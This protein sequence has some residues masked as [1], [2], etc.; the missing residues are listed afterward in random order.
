MSKEKIWMNG[1]YLDSSEGVINISTSAL[2]YG[3]SIFEGILCIMAGSGKTS[4]V[5]RLQDHIDRMFES[6]GVLNYKIPYSRE[7]LESAVIGLV[8]INKYSSC[9]IRP[10]VFEDSGYLDFGNKKNILNIVILCKSF[11]HI[12][13]RWKMRS[14]AKIMISKTVRNLWPDVLIKA[15]ISGKYLASVIARREAEN[16]GFDD[17]LLLDSPGNVSEATSSNIFIIKSGVIKTPRRE[18]T[19]NGITQNSVMRIAK[20]FGYSVAEED[21]KVEDLLDADEAFLTNTAAGIVPISSIDSKKVFERNKE[22]LAKILR[23]KYIDIITGKDPKYQ[24]WLS[25]VRI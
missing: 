2:H 14:R 5:F 15:K 1:K 21:I 12:L 17:A 25:Y 19:L 16:N 11:N 7:E 20:D 8:K 23:G 24:E 9:Y 18:N 6:A 3:T 22:G 10:I 4:A 13:Y